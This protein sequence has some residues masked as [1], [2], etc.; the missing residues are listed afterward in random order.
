MD[1]TKRMDDD[2]DG[3]GGRMANEFIWE[4]SNGQPASHPVPE[5]AD[6]LI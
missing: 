4:H 2:G 6:K 5:T 3:W 1:E